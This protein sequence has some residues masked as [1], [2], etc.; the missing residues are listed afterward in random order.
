[1][2]IF[3]RFPQIII[4]IPRKHLYLHTDPFKP[5]EIFSDVELCQLFFGTTCNLHMG[6]AILLPALTSHPVSY[7]HGRR[8]T[9]HLWAGVSGKIFI[10]LNDTRDWI[11]LYSILY[12]LFVHFNKLPNTSF[13]IKAK[14]SGLKCVQKIHP[15]L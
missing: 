5:S 12:L 1:M 10:V 9:G 4:W 15:H 8:C 2:Y 7:K 11:L 13:K 6:A 14:K 3:L